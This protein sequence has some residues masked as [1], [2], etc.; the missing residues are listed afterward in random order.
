MAVGGEGEGVR[1]SITRGST[2]G[3][4][5]YTPSWKEGGVLDTWLTARVA[6]GIELGGASRPIRGLGGYLQLW[7]V[8]LTN[9]GKFRALLF[10]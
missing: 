9:L 8:N 5:G 6:R 1:L 7:L 10:Y 4:S 3:T 2:A